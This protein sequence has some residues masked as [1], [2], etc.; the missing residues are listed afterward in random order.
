MGYRILTIMPE[1]FFEEFTKRRDS[2]YNE[3]IRIADGLPQDA[4]FVEYRIKPENHNNLELVFESE[5]WNEENNFDYV[6]VT[7]ESLTYHK[8]N[9]EEV[10]NAVTDLTEVEQ[11]E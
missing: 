3:L 8:E 7:F 10:K 6:D 5:E 11:D 2:D 1:L 9:Y 4:K